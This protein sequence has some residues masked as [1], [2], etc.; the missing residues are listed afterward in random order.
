MKNLSSKSTWFIAFFS[1][2]KVIVSKSLIGRSSQHTSAHNLAFKTNSPGAQIRTGVGHTH[3]RRRGFAATSS[4]RSRTSCSFWP[5]ALCFARV[6]LGGTYVS[7]RLLSARRC[8][9]GVSAK[10]NAGSGTCA[11]RGLAC[12]VSEHRTAGPRRTVRATRP[13]ARGNFRPLCLFLRHE[14][15]CAVDLFS[16]S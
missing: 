11:E 10:S 8:A 2:S 7:V 3:R 12:V 14:A 6:T 9:T 16:S 13:L 15:V 4:F 5:I 1:S